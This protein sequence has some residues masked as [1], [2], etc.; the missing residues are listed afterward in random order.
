MWVRGKGG[1]GAKEYVVERERSAD[2][3]SVSRYRGRRVRTRVNMWV[4][5]Y[6]RM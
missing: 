6:I 1:R 3:C 5:T 2:K 4:C